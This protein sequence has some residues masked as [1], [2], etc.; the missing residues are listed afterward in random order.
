[1]RPFVI[2]LTIPWV[3]NGF[4]RVPDSKSSLF[5]K[6]PKFFSNKAF[7][8]FLLHLYMAIPSFLDICIHKVLYT[9]LNLSSTYLSDTF[10][11]IHYLYSYLKRYLTDLK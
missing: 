10:Q 11:N 2:P 9:Y 3:Q 7:V 8:F 6:F 1:M 4:R 5:L